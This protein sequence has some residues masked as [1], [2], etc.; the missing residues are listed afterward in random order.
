MESMEKTNY[1]VYICELQ[2]LIWFCV[3]LSS[4]SGQYEESFSYNMQISPNLIIIPLAQQ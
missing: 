3:L 2:Y 4:D 1:N